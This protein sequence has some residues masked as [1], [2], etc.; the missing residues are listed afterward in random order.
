MGAGYQNGFG[1]AL[2]FS[3]IPFTA[4]G[5]APGTLPGGVY[6]DDVPTPP[7]VDALTA[8]GAGMHDVPTSIVG[9]WL[10]MSSYHVFHHRDAVVSAEAAR[11]RH[12]AAT[13]LVASALAAQSAHL[14]SGRRA[15]S[16]SDDPDSDSATTVG[17]NAADLISMEK[18]PPSWGGFS[19]SS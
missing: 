5:H 19:A 16:R 18:P 6:C 13:A 9:G 1:T 8:P 17:R 12:H 3:I 10:C 11:G 2:N 14:F 4:A 7:L 15:C